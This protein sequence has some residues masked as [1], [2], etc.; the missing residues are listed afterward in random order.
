MNFKVK[1][2]ANIG[3]DSAY[4]FGKVGTI[5]EVKN[6]ILVDLL[7]NRWIADNIE[8]INEKFGINGRMQTLFELVEEDYNSLLER[9]QQFEEEL[10]K[11]KQELGI[12]GSEELYQV[13]R[14]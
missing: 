10:L 3:S 2:V 8:H 4:F 1:V 6:S 11:I 12:L 7:D 14:K 9:M 13:E 5:H